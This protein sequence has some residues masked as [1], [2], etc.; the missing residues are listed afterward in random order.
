MPQTP[1]QGN[2]WSTWVCIQPGLT[3]HHHGNWLERNTRGKEGVCVWWKR[4][5][6]DNAWMNP[7]MLFRLC[8]CQLLCSTVCDAFSC[9]RQILQRNVG[10]SCK[11]KK[12]YLNQPPLC[13]SISQVRFQWQLVWI[14]INELWQQFWE[15]D[16]FYIS[17]TGGHKKLF[18]TK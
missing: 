16:F 3:Y 2:D 4:G 5:L 12:T 6:F 1:P 17:W 14:K 7:I 11:N 15:K 18:F 13:L 8:M 9:N 10:L